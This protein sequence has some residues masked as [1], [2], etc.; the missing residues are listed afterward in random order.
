MYLYYKAL[1]SISSYSK[2]T[3]KKTLCPYKDV[4]VIHRTGNN[5]NSHQ[6]MNEL[7]YLHTIEYPFSVKCNKLLIHRTMLMDFRSFKLKWKK[8]D[9]KVYILQD[10]IYV[11]FW[12]RQTYVNGNQIS[13]YQ[14]LGMREGNEYWRGT[15][16]IAWDDANIL[17]VDSGDSV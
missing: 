12:K 8:S 9:T 2:K 11:I 14:G 1:Q 13:N 7:W 3:K 4:Y 5:P 15:K 6:L 16:G 17:Y 10:S